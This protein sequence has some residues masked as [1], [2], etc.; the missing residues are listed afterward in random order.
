MKA[1]IGEY[2]LGLYKACH[3]HS[4]LTTARLVCGWQGLAIRS[5]RVNERGREGG[6]EE[7]EKERL[8]RG[9]LFT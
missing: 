2:Q 6:R 3:L 1:S 4:G 5:R 7:R 9:Q 8:V